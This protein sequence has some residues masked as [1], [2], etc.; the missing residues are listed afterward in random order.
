ME[1]A[2]PDAPAAANRDAGRYIG[3]FAPAPTGDLHFGSVVTALASWLR[4]RKQH[5]RWLVRIEDLDTIRAL[6]GADQRILRSLE[7]LGLGWD[8]PVVW[9]SQ[10]DALYRDALARIARSARCYPCACSRREVGGAR[11]AG[12][13][14]QGLSGNKPALSLR[15]DVSGRQVRVSDALQG[16]LHQDLEAELGDFVIQRGDGLIAYHLAVVV[17]D[18]DQGITEIVRGADIWDSTPRQVE[19]QQL[20]NL[21]TPAY[22]H[23]PVAIAPDGR[24]LSKQNAAPPVDR[25]PPGQ[26][27]QDALRFLGFDPPATL[28][29]DAPGE[30]LAWALRHWNLAA[31]P[32]SAA[33]PAPLRH[34]GPQAPLQGEPD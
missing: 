31:L 20:L 11:Y 29:P 1:V 30:W 21:P 17:D 22:V 14:R 15:L 25:L 26:V 16:E 24:K 19:L 5:G 4:A 2:G 9:Q 7:Q 23:I 13:C 6:P 34:V 28:S 12:T 3:R 27:L 8:G 10:R 33:Q 32:R 18:A